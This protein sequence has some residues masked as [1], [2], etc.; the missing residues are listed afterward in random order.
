MFPFEYGRLKMNDLK[1]YTARWYHLI[2]LITLTA[3]WGCRGDLQQPVYQ[4]A[5]DNPAE[6]GSQFPY[7]FLDNSGTLYMSWITY[8]DED[9]HALQFA[10]YRENGW[11]TAQT[12]RVATNFFVNWA[13]FPSIV[14]FDDSPV[15]VQWLRKVE[16]GPYAYYVQIGFQDESTG[17][18][19]H[20]ITPHLDGT[21]TEHGFVSM[22]PLGPNRVL[23][24]W[25][26]GRETDGRGHGEYDDFSKSMTLRSAEVSA[27]GEIVRKRVIDSTV[28]DCCQTDLAEVNGDYLAVYRGRTEEEIRDIKISRYSSENGEWSEPKTVHNDGWEIQGCPVNGPRIVTNDNRVAVIWYTGAE[29]NTGVKLARSVDG[30]ETFQEPILIADEGALGRPDLLM[31]DDGTIYV[32]WMQQVG[33]AG[34]VQL[35]RIGPDGSLNEAISVGNTSST[36]RSGFPRIAKVDNQIIVAWTQTEPLLRVRTAKVE[37]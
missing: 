22:Q 32:S 4:Y 11:S 12:V 37:I 29:D 26:D 8:I 9:I 3:I 28:C 23:A 27:D 30:G 6:T 18:W 34:H 7:L 21:P 1:R 15:A 13:D 35:K 2:L 10:T 17:R 33:S 24:M 36:R 14:G 19:D 31:T 16:G 25:L 5:M 20:I